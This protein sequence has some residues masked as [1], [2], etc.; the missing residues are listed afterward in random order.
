MILHLYRMTK[1]TLELTQCYGR[2]KSFSNTFF[3]FCI[4]KWNKLDAKLR[5]L[6]SFSRFKKLLSVYLKTDQNSIFDVHNPIGIKLLNRLTLHFGHLNEHKF[7]H[8]FRDAVNPPCLCNAETETTS[9]Y[10]LCCPSFSEKR[11][12]LLESL[13]Y[14]DITI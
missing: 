14:L 7:H 5:N 9:H 2:T 8:N 10:L 3:P 12:N 6:P 1:S 11:T 13:H 4:K